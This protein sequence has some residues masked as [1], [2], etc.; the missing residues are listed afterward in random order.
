[1]SVWRGKF[2]ETTGTIVLDREA[3]TGTVDITIDTASID[4]GLDELDN[5]LKSAMPEFFDVDEISRPP[6]TRAS[7]RSSRT[8]RPPKCRAS[9][10]CMA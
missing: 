3:K 4:I 9:S 2:N 6:P 7:S 5:H 8:A 1:M 10:R